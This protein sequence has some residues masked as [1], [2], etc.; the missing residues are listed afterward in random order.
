MGLQ[1]FI[2]YHAILKTLYIIGETYECDRTNDKHFKCVSEQVSH[3]PP[4]VAQY[5][6]SSH[7]DSKPGETPAWRCWQEFTMRSRF[8]GK[9]LEVEPLGIAHLVF[10]E[11]GNHYT[12]RKGE[13]KGHTSTI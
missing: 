1:F 8:K 5:C 2:I 7:P 12:W 10:P 9:Y 13:L 11:S 4:M 3:H 6:E